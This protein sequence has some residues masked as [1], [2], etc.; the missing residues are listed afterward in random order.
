MPRYYTGCSVYQV[1]I[2]RALYLWG[3]I[4]NSKREHPIKNVPK[5]LRARAHSCCAGALF[6]LHERA[7]EGDPVTPDPASP[8]DILF[9]LPTSSDPDPTLANKLLYV[10]AAHANTAIRHGL[11]SPIVLYIAF[12]IARACELQGVDPRKTGVYGP[13]TAL[14][15]EHEVRVAEIQEEQRKMAAKIA[16]APNAYVCAAQG[17]GIEGSKKASLMRCAGKCPAERKPH[18]CSKECQKMVSADPST[19][20]YV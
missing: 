18:Y 12:E 9:L 1:N 15:R 8:S 4:L 5:D 3:L 16:R 2:H 14:W 10:A 17:C 13:F 11:V 19:R 7:F 20:S 6:S